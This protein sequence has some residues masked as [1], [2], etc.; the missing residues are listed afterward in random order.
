MS[1]VVSCTEFGIGPITTK[2]HVLV[3]PL[4]G[5]LKRHTV[6]IIFSCLGGTVK[7]D[8]ETNGPYDELRAANVTY[9]LLS[10]VNY[11]HSHGI[12]YLIARP[13]LG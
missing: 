6:I 3:H 12:R 1:L 5:V 7:Q 9:Q 2:T 13:L 10:A 4:H 11:L 8:I